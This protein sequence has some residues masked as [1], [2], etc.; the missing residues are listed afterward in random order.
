M[1]IKWLWVHYVISSYNAKTAKRNILW[2][3]SDA[4]PRQCGPSTGICWCRH[5][6][7]QWHPRRWLRRSRRR[8]NALSCTQHSHLKTLLCRPSQQTIP[9]LKS[10][11]RS[12][13]HHS[14][15]DA[16]C[17]ALSLVVDTTTLHTFNGPLSGTAW[18]SWYQK[19]KSNLDF[20]EARDSEWQWHQLGHMQVCTSLQTDYHA[21]TPP[22]SFLQAGCP[23][24]RPTH[25]IKELKACWALSLVADI[26]Q[27]LPLAPGL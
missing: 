17:W 11:C 1:A 12:S 4:R 10:L 20:T 14:T 27:Y 3:L 21:N 16:C 25:S 2:Y 22:L 19:G 13:L 9:L 5:P 7:N 18:V 8:A 23:S 15:D 26:D 6:S 24:C